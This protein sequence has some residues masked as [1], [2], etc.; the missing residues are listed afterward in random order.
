[1]ARVL[2]NL[3]PALNQ[4]VFLE[5][6]D[7]RDASAG[8]GAAVSC[9]VQD[10]EGHEL[11]LLC[12][13]ALPGGATLKQGDRVVLTYVRPRGVCRIEGEVAR[14]AESAMARAAEGLP[15]QAGKAGGACAADAV[16]WPGVRVR[17]L[18]VSC[19]QRR[20]Y[21][22]WRTSLPARYAVLDEGAL[23]GGA[24]DVEPGAWRGAVTVDIST[25]GVR[26]RTR[27]PLEEGALLLVRV[28]LPEGEVEAMGRVVRAWEESPGRVAKL[29]QVGVDFARLTVWGRQAIMRFIC[30]QERRLRRWGL[31]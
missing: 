11:L 22:R 29:Y 8:A 10:V 7:G 12:P 31:S 2:S 4:R 18:S 27:E 23:A 3:L 28:S 1:M 5:L 25:G 15:V 6:A 30:S 16:P 19:D 26:L 24:E 14:A 13:P 20:R 21:F 9:L 17:V